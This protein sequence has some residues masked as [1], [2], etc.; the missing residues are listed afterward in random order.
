MMSIPFPAGGRLYYARDL[1]KMA[2]VAGI[3]LKDESF[4]IGPDAR[5]SMWYGRRSQLEVD[6]GPCT[7]LSA[8]SNTYSHE[9]TDNYR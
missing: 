3:P 1:R 7:P 2:G 4:C 6:R 9:L 5:L 8:F